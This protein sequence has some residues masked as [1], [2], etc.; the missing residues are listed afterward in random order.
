MAMD[1]EKLLSFFQTHYLS[2]QEVLYKLPLNLSIDSFWAELLNRRKACATVLPLYN[3]S[4]MPYWFVLTDG[5]VAASERLC[6]EMLNQADTFIDPYRAQMT[7]AMTEEMFFTSFVEGAQIPLQEAMDFL[8]RG[9]EPEN[10][11]EQMI[12]NNRHAW[13][14]LVA[15]LYRPLDEPMIKSLAYMLTEEMDGCAEDYRLADNHPIAAMNDEPYDVPPSF[16]LPDRMREYCAFLQ[17]PDVHPLI[18]AAV[19]QAYIL[20]ARPFSE[21]NERLSRMLSSAVLLRCGYD[22]FR[23]ISLSA[24]IARESYRY[25]K[26][27]REIIRAENGCDLTYFM[28]YYL[29]LLVRSVDNRRERLQRRELEAIEQERTL[30]KQPFR[31][32]DREGSISKPMKQET[33]S[34][35][36]NGP[37]LQASKQ[38]DVDHMGD[39]VSDHG[40]NTAVG[41]FLQ[42]VDEIYAASNHPRGRLIPQRIREMLHM[43]ITEFT[44]DKWAQ[45]GR[46]SSKS[47]GTAVARMF[48]K[49]ILWRKKVDHQWIYGFMIPASG[50]TYDDRD[51]VQESTLC[52]RRAE[53]KP[54]TMSNGFNAGDISDV[55]LMS[56]DSLPENFRSRLQTLKNDP[57]SNVNRQIGRY[58]LDLICSG[59]QGF[60]SRDWEES[61]HFPKSTVRN[62]ITKALGMGLIRLRRSCGGTTNIYFI[63]PNECPS[64]RTDSMTKTQRECLT[65]LYEIFCSKEFTLNEGGKAMNWSSS[66]LY[67]Y[68]HVFM[69]RGIM[70]V[71]RDQGQIYYYSIKVTPETNPECFT[72]FHKTGSIEKSAP[73]AAQRL[74]SLQAIA[75]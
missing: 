15:T 36:N 73:R 32:P 3:A 67:N 47:A 27:M 31:P 29:Q 8:Q 9:T 48:A 5:M 41:M 57:H 2:R 14:E 20:V 35:A 22:F 74:R 6:E 53:Q 42:K 12:W 23:D 1:K 38:N 75:V 33:V 16:A 11:Q 34:K 4:G 37:A 50:I 66:S 72:G 43:G 62:Y 60:I 28:E 30:A 58:L 51:T 64:I 54:A 59:K 63:S 61:G 26:S 13:A 40:G 7:S 25:Y 52:H 17:K 39:A 45:Y 19:A 68:V 44:S 65:H 71:R 24:V 10:I 46:I 56:I 18:K 49:G 69:D 70:S 55:N 21:G